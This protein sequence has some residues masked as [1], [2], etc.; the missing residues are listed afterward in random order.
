MDDIIRGYGDKGQRYEVRATTRTGQGKVIGWTDIADG[1]SIAE[2]A[3]GAVHLKDVLVVDRFPGIEK[4]LEDWKTFKADCRKCVS[5]LYAGKHGCGYC[6]CRFP[7][8]RKIIITLD[9]GGAVP[10]GLIL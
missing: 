2:S 1:G 6:G 9:E 7:K 5:Q 4:I 10:T 8:K 3:R